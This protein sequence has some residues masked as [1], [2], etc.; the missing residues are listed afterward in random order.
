MCNERG[1]TL[2]EDQLVVP[3]V[4]S[5]WYMC[6]ERGTTL[7]EDQLVVPVVH[8]SWCRLTNEVQLYQMTSL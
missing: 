5:S 1:T 4:H 7:S 8:S 3:V 6:N 2:T